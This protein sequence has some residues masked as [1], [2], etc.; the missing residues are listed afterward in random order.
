MNWLGD[1]HGIRLVIDVEAVTHEQADTQQWELALVGDDL[2]AFPLTEP[3]KEAIIRIELQDGTVGESSCHLRT[4][5]K[6]Q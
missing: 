1:E 6:P 4:E 5:R 2:N 3:F